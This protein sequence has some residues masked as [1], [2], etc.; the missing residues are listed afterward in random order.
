MSR[1]SEP[2]SSLFFFQFSSKISNKI[3]KKNRRK[4]VWKIDDTVEDDNFDR[5]VELLTSFMYKTLRIRTKNIFRFA[6]VTSSSSRDEFF[7]TD[8][9]RWIFL[10]RVRDQRQNKC[11]L[12]PILNIFS[13]ET[14]TSRVPKEYGNFLVAL[15]HRSAKNRIWSTFRSHYGSKKKKK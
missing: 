4:Y 14:V 9:S 10:N 11:R 5:L 1:I 3:M 7:F 8:R 13:S 12:F 15:C 2:N 6:S